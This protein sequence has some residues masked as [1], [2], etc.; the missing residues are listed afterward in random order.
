M[1]MREVLQYNHMQCMWYAVYAV[2]YEAAAA[3]YV[4][5]SYVHARGPLV[6]LQSAII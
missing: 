5:A 1:C 6:S 4:V 2:A 3:A